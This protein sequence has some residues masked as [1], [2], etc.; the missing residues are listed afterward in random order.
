M[1]VAWDEDWADLFLLHLASPDPIARHEAALAT[2]VAAFSAR[3]AE[4]ARTLLSE[5]KARETFPKL[6]QTL[7][8]AIAAVE[9]LG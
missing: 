6:E 5:A 3:Q 2:V 7:I 1:V 4:P 8:E 9:G